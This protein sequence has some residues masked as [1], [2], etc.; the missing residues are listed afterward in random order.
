MKKLIITTAIILGFSISTHAQLN[1][2]LKSKAKDAVSSTVNN[3]ANKA[4]NL[5]DLKKGVSIA[6]PSK[7]TKGMEGTWKV[8]GVIVNTDNEGLKS[9]LVAQEKQYNDEYNGYNWKFKADGSID[10][11]SKSGNG[12][13]EYELAGDKINMQINNQIGEY[14]LQFEEGQMILTQTTPLNTVIFVFVKG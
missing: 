3:T 7:N 10:I 13:G 9:Q 12:K 6:A 2:L 1:G 4:T 14:I 8:E 5:S 11:T